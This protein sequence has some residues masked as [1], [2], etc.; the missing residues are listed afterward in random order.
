MGDNDKMICDEE[1][2]SLSI[3]TGFGV[4]IFGSFLLGGTPQMSGGSN[5]NSNSCIDL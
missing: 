1:A 4:C 3:E 5:L 2:G